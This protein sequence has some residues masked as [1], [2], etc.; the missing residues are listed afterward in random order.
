MKWRNLRPQIRA[1]LRDTPVVSGA[2][3]ATVAREPGLAPGE[4]SQSAAG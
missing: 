2:L 1:A 4:D 3:A